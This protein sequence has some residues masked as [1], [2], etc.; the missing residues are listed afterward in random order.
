MNN[1]ATCRQA[2]IDRFF[3]PDIS[4]M[5]RNTTPLSPMV[6][7]FLPPVSQPGLTGP[8][9]EALTLVFGPGSGWVVRRCTVA[10]AT[11]RTM[12]H[13]AV[14][15]VRAIRRAPSL[16]L[17]PT[18][19]QRAMTGLNFDPGSV[20]SAQ[21]WLS[22]HSTAIWAALSCNLYTHTRETFFFFF[23]F[24]QENCRGFDAMFVDLR[25]SAT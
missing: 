18:W 14:V 12:L 20:R 15:V 17:V 8:Q 24:L 21:S 1:H 19:V 6:C 11:G 22:L 9:S 3:L 25:K 7:T 23:S 2:Q 10:T 16:G 4:Q 5:E 13:L